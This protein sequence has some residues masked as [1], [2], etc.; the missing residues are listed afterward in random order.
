[1]SQILDRKT[2]SLEE[3]ER[4][5]ELGAFSKDDRIELIR[6]ELT[7]MSPIGVRHIRVVTRLNRLLSGLMSSGRADVS[8]QNPLRLPPNSEPEPDLVVLLPESQ[9]ANDMPSP[10][11]ALLVIEVADSSLQVDR[12]VKLPLYAESGVREY[13]IVDLQSNTVEVYRNPSGGVYQTKT[14]HS[15][16]ETIYTEAFPDYPVELGEVLC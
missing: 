9:C 16:S 8:V 15:S 2:F 1:M 7:L 11:D 4:M 13:W 3:Y 12:S 5:V 14:T 10:A 6:G